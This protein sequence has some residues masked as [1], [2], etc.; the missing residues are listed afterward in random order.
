MTNQSGLHGVKPTLAIVIAIAALNLTSVEAQPLDMELFKGMKARSI[1]PAGMSGRVTAIEVV[2]SD[3]DVIYAGTASG[4]LWR[5]T[6]GGTTWAPIFD[7]QNAASIGGHSVNDIPSRPPFVKGGWGDL[8]TVVGSVAGMIQ[9]EPMGDEGFGYDPVFYLP[10]Y[11]KTMGQL[12]LVDKNRISHRADATRKVVAV[13][14]RLAN[15]AQ[16]LIADR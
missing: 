4:G 15:G 12:S 13:L 5:S 8:V 14:Q 11:G 6:N 7:E 1:G 9:Y 16:R 2:D 10:S 3:K